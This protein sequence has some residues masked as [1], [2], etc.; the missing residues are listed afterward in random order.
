MKIVLLRTPRILSP[1]IK[2]VITVVSNK[3]IIKK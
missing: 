1:I 3:P 2:K